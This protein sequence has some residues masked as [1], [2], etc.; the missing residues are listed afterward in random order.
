MP[1][2]S[3]TCHGEQPQLPLGR[4]VSN[5]FQQRVRITTGEP[6]GLSHCVTKL[7]D[8]VGT[9]IRHRLGGP[10][11]TLL[12]LRDSSWMMGAARHLDSLPVRCCMSS[13]PTFL[14]GACARRQ[15]RAS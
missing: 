8:V 13:I 14:R 11:P 2:P 9:S 1:D 10:A 5:N 7:C 3:A 4:S 12:L 6:F 15:V